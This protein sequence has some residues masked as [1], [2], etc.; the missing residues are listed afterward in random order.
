MGSEV[1]KKEPTIASEVKFEI[2]EEGNLFSILHNG[3]YKTEPENIIK[4]VDF[5]QSYG[6]SKKKISSR[7]L[8][9]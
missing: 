2:I 8:L 9:I 6:L 7:N 1:V 4:I 5:I 3:V